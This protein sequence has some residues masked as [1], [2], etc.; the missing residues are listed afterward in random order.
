MNSLAIFATVGMKIC[1]TVYVNVACWRYTNGGTK[2]VANGPSNK[3][4]G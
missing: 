2:I 4:D 3:Y 1:K